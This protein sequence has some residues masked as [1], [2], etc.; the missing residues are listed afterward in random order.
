MTCLVFSMCLMGEVRHFFKHIWVA[1]SFL[2]IHSLTYQFYFLYPSE[3]EL[4]LE[5]DT[6]QLSTSHQKWLGK[7]MRKGEHRVRP[8]QWGSIRKTVKYV[9]AGKQTQWW[10]NLTLRKKH[11]LSQVGSNSST[12]GHCFLWNTQSHSQMFVILLHHSKE[13]KLFVQLH[14]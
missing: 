10:G 7:C 3:L 4:H 13:E 12:S 1:R 11:T 8:G 2:L 9:T 14:F 6:R 5:T